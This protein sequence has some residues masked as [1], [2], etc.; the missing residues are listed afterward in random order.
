MDLKVIEDAIPQAD[1]IYKAIYKM[2]YDWWFY[3][4]KYGDNPP[5]YLRYSLEQSQDIKQIQ[6]KIQASVQ[7]NYFTY[8][9]SRTYMHKEACECFVC[10]RIYSLLTNKFT[11]L[12]GPVTLGE[13]FISSYEAGDFLSEHHDKEKGIAFS[14]NLSKDW[15]QEYGGVLSLKYP[16]GI[17]SVVPSFNTLSIFN[18][19]EPTDHWVSEVSS[20]APSKRLA[21]TGWF[22]K[23]AI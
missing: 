4:Y 18:I 22:T 17:F 5:E 1:E 6:N 19:Q 23:N 8:K 16:E 3:S 11:E 12:F 10:S 21:V 20:L 7:A 14:W 9:F 13:Y 2:T 15:K